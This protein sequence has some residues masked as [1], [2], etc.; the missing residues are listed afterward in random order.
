MPGGHVEQLEVEFVAFDF[1]AL[2]DGKAH[3]PENA[4]DLAQGNRGRV[5][6]AERLGTA[7]Q[8]H[9]NAFGGHLLR[10]SPLRP[11]RFRLFVQGL[12]G[13]LDLVA[14]ASHHRAFFPRQRAYLAQNV[15][16]FAALAQETAMP[17]LQG[18]FDLRLVGRAYRCGAEV[19]QLLD[20]RI[21]GHAS[22]PAGIDLFDARIIYLQNP[23]SSSAHAE[24]YMT[25]AGTARGPRRNPRPMICPLWRSVASL[26]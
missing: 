24:F 20:E 5:Q 14:G 11:F 17:L 16:E 15:G 6:F 22:V 7:R 3:A 12:Q 26:A 19:M 10:Q 23:A 18:F 1:P 9:V 8:R 2:V 4:V 21:L 13:L 25:P